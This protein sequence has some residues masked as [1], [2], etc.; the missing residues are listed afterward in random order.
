MIR[1]ANILLKKPPARFSITNTMSGRTIEVS[2]LMYW[3]CGQG[4]ILTVVTQV[5]LMKMIALLDFR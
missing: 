4:F 3:G 1:N 2:Q 5:F